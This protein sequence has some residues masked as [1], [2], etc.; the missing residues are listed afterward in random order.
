MGSTQSAPERKQQNDAPE[1]KQ[2][3][4]VKHAAKES[5]AKSHNDAA[6]GGGNEPAVRPAVEPKS[7]SS[8]L[9]EPLDILQGHRDKITF[10]DI[11]QTL[12][13]QTAIQNL[14]A[15]RAAIESG[16]FTRNSDGTVDK[17][18]AQE[19]LSMEFANDVTRLK[20]RVM[21]QT[22]GL[23]DP[24][25]TYMQA[26]AR[27]HARACIPSTRHAFLA[28]VHWRPA[29]MQLRAVW[30]GAVHL[31]NRRINFALRTRTHHRGYD[32][33]TCLDLHRHSDAV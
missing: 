8:V 12:G 33:W 15:T 6:K 20:T 19:M 13:G 22:H 10:Q 1:R 31:P 29:T 7:G 5:V 27:I 32:M 18:A 28:R 2:Q 24:R 23:L 21:S 30:S 9:T 4:A 25:S 14:N 3:E 16:S 26:C 17:A 11:V